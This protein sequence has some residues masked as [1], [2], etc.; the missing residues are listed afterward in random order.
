MAETPA[1]KYIKQYNGGD[2][3]YPI[4]SVDAVF[5]LSD[6]LGLLATTEALN[7]GLEDLKAEIL[8]DD[9]EETFNTL[10][11]VQ[12]WAD[13]HGTDYANLVADVNNKVDWTIDDKGNKCIVM[14][15]HGMLIG[16]PNEG[17]Q[18]GKADAD[19]NCN[20]I[21]LS[22]WNVVDLGSVKYPINLNGIK[23]R[24]TY[25]DDKELALLS[26]V[27]DLE[28]TV[29]GEITTKINDLESKL[30]VLEKKHDDEL[31]TTNNNVTELGNR[32]GAIE[33]DLTDIKSRLTNLETTLS[34]FMDNNFVLFSD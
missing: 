1:I 25:N 20:L 10:K 19:G 18:E 11:A 7:K 3:I 22:K 28:T 24:P 9:L 6:R 30:N 14:S 32:V 27:T 31:V 16:S 33:T 4:T 34:T 26:D 29:T 21:M 8:G 2:I 12:E 13:E 15:N 5:G 17:E 23:E